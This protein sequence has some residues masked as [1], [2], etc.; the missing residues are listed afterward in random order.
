MLLGYATKKNNRQGVG[1][2]NVPQFVQVLLSFDL[3]FGCFCS[4]DKSESHIHNIYMEWLLQPCK[5]L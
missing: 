2:G 5:K 1:G 4:D 3:L